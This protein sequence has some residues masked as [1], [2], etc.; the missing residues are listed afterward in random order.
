ME[1]GQLIQTSGFG[2]LEAMSAIEVRASLVLGMSVSSFLASCGLAHVPCSDVQIMDPKMDSGIDAEGVYTFE[3]AEKAGL[4]PS[5]L[6]VPEVIA[7]MDELF[8]CEVPLLP[9]DC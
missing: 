3:E 5:E 4:L 8:C 2:L 6:S 9:V 1:L 7:I